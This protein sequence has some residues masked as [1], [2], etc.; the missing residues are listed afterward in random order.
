MTE[1]ELH[2]RVKELQNDSV[3]LYSFVVENSS[4]ELTDEEID[5]KVE[6]LEGDYLSLREFVINAMES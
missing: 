6:E 2:G 1:D 4:E 5:E 3:E